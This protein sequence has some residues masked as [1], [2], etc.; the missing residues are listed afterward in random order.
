LTDT[1]LDAARRL[2]QAVAAVDRLDEAS[3][4]AVAEYTAALEQLTKPALT[5]IV[6]TLRADPRGKELL[7]E[8]LDDEAVRLVLAMHGIIRLPDPAGA[9]GPGRDAAG[10]PF[11]P[12]NALF[13]KPT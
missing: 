7:F 9:P 13:R 5:A 4:A 11:V 12:L 1:F 2:D 6:T 10:A 3:R 8:L